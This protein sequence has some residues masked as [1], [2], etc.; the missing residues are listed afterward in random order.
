MRCD[1]GHVEW[2]L[3]SHQYFAE[4]SKLKEHSKKNK[5]KPEKNK[6]SMERVILQTAEKHMHRKRTF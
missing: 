1:T 6:V 5:E 4:I 2:P 3:E